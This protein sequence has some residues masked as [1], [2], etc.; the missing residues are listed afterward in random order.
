METPL[1]IGANLKHVSLD[2]VKVGWR[3]QNWQKNIQFHPT[4]I[5]S[6]STDQSKAV[7]RLRCES[8]RIRLRD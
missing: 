3:L 7:G 1:P 5:L 6:I 4:P 8:A 2:A